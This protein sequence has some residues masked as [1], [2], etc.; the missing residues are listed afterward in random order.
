MPPKEEIMIGPRGKAHEHEV[1]DFE[2]CDSG[3]ACLIVCLEP[4]LAPPPPFFAYLE[5]KRAPW[6]WSILGAVKEST[7]SFFAAAGDQ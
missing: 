2:P 3:L 4:L 6:N 7:L 5:N 1:T